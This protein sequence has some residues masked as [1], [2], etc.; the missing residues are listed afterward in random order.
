MR[1]ALETERELYGDHQ[2]RQHGHLMPDCVM[3]SQLA[4]DKFGQRGRKLGRYRDGDRRRRRDSAV[5]QLARGFL[6][7]LFADAL[8]PVRERESGS[9]RHALHDRSLSTATTN[10][11]A[12]PSETN[13]F[14][15][16]RSGRTRRST[17]PNNFGP[18]YINGGSAD[19]QGAFNCTGCTIVLTNKSTASNAT[20]GTFSSNAQATNNITAPT[21]G[22]SRAS[23]FIR[24]G[25]ATDCGMQQGQWRLGVRH[26]R[27]DVLPK[28]G[29]VVQRQ[30][31]RA[32]NLHD[33]RCKAHHL[34]RQQRR[35]EQV[36][37]A[38]RLHSP[39][40]C[41]PPVP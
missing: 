13:C 2:Q 27:R 29:A 17:I 30:R 40:A 35:F 1:Q 20:I 26:Y 36:Q 33:V 22:R 32:G 31:H 41:L 3:Y 18:I 38:L 37:E 5:E 24:I 11:N 25:A 23:R 7:S 8:R 9:E 21:T 16:C 14:R 15:R 4:V 12:L 28:P 10:F 6:P 39:K 19:L 34:H